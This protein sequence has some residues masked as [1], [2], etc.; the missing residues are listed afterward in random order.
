MTL[1]SKLS[2]YEEYDS[3]PIGFHGHHKWLLNGL[4]QAAAG[5]SWVPAKSGA[6]R[7]R[8]VDVDVCFHR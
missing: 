6:W 1:V 8:V 2:R 5:A 4:L 7:V 3:P